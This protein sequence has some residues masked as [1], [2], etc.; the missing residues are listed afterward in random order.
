MAGG[1]PA[2]KVVAFGCE[3]CEFESSHRRSTSTLG[4]PLLAASFSRCPNEQEN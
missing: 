2:G 1:D 3:G 4:S